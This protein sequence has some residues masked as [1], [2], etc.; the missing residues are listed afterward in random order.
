MARVTENEQDSER[1]W[2]MSFER[3]ILL[4]SRFEFG[5]EFELGKRQR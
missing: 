5:V 1:K 2:S 3:V 4:V